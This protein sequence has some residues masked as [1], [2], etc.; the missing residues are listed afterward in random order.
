MRTT[1]VYS[2]KHGYGKEPMTAFSAP[3]ADAMFLRRKPENPVSFAAARI[4]T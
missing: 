3:V 1:G 2:K 4:G